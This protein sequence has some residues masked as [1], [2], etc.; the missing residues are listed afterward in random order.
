MYPRAPKYPNEALIAMSEE[1]DAMVRRKMASGEGYGAP[2]PGY[3]YPEDR[4][5]EAVVGNWK[6][7][8]RRAEEKQAATQARERAREQGRQRKAA[9]LAIEAAAAVPRHR[10]AAPPPPPPRPSRYRA[11]P[12]IEEYNELP[13]YVQSVV[14]DSG[15]LGTFTG[16][17]RMRRGKGLVPSKEDLEAG[18]VCLECMPRALKGKEHP[19]AR[20]Y[21]ERAELAA[22]KEKNQRKFDKMMKRGQS[23]VEETKQ[24]N[25]LAK[26]G[27]EIIQKDIQITEDFLA[28]AKDEREKTAA[29][30]TLEELRNK[31]QQ[32]HAE[33]DARLSPRRS[34][35]QVQPSPPA[36]PRGIALEEEEEVPNIVPV[37]GRRSL[38]VR[39]QAAEARQLEEDLARKLNAA[40]DKDKAQHKRFGETGFF[41]R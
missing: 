16:V 23:R 21:R 11:D 17:G 19:I 33:N 30:L 31:E 8:Q 28:Q 15:A 2:P 5:A 14:K 18:K 34:P 36:S 41:D 27:L 7:S 9:A 24:R 4:G 1:Y 37:R 3:I 13:P 38:T 25:Q 40:I 32:W 12:V 6:V 22:L 20:M 10:A 39:D 26:I 35:A 29:E